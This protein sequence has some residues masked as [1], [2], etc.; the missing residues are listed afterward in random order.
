MGPLFNLGGR[1]ALITGSCQSIGLGLAG[2]LAECGARIVLNGRE[3][4]K[5]AP[6]GRGVAGAQLAAFDVADE[7]AVETG[8]AMVEFDLGPIDILV[9]DAGVQLRTPVEDFPVARWRELFETN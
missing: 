4:A 5:L 1:R 6:A 7:A 9:N 3:K 8:I 2:G